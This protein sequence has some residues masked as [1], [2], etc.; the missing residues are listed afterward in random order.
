MKTSKA[1]GYMFTSTFAKRFIEV[2]GGESWTQ[3]WVFYGIFPSLHSFWL[4]RCRKVQRMRD[5]DGLGLRKRNVKEGALAHCINDSANRKRDERPVLLIYYVWKRIR[6]R[7]RARTFSA[8]S[9]CTERPPHK[10]LFNW[11]GVPVDR[12]PT[13]KPGQVWPRVDQPSESGAELGKKVINGEI[14]SAAPPTQRRRYLQGD[15]EKPCRPP[16]DKPAGGRG[17][18]LRP[19]GAAGGA[20][21]RRLPRRCAPDTYRGL[22]SGERGRE[23][24]ARREAV[25]FEQPPNGLRGNSSPFS[26]PC[27][28]CPFRASECFSGKLY[29]ATGGF[30]AI[31]NFLTTQ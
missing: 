25:G 4:R 31:S 16:E 27:F 15:K 18:A 20:G 28:L 1:H 9:L 11:R 10:W 7:A 13:V 14:A 21:L 24:G 12:S 26:E 29:I 19:S 3:L 2:S 8:L 22:P 30:L 17:G 5:V 6:I 23:R